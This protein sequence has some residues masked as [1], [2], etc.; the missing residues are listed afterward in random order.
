MRVRKNMK[1]KLMLLSDKLLLCR[2]GITI[3]S[4]NDQLK[5]ICQI[6]YSRHRSPWNFQKASSSTFSVGKFTNHWTNMVQLLI[7]ILVGIMALYTGLIFKSCGDFLF[8]STLY[9]IHW[10]HTEIWLSASLGRP[11]VMYVRCCRAS[12]F[13]SMYAL[14][15]L[16]LFPL[17]FRNMEFTDEIDYRLRAFV[18]AMVK[19]SLK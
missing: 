6:E 9:A 7:I 10:R 11:L 17:R 13:W 1:N 14:S 12:S 15:W 8:A 3:E 4:V 19:R 5:N 18:W 2:R 16:Y